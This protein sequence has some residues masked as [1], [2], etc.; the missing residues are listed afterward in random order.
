VSVV[1]QTSSNTWGSSLAY[2]SELMGYVD[3]PH[4]EG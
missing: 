3:R 2:T 1:V 4:A